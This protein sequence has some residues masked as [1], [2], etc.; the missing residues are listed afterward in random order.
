MYV[1]Y[2][3]MLCMCGLVW[4]VCT[5]VCHYITC[6]V[7]LYVYVVYVWHVCMLG[8]VC[9]VCMLCVLYD[10]HAMYVCIV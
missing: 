2:V 6:D 9:Y 1:N 7:L 8:Y 10:T 5:Y 3:C 4:Y